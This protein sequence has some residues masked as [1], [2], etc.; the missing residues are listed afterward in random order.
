MQIE[1]PKSAISASS[2]H[3]L[4][5]ADKFKTKTAQSYV[6]ELAM[7]DIGIVDDFDN[8]AMRHGRNNQ[9]DAYMLAVLPTFPNAVWHDEY[10]AIDDRCGASPDVL[11]GNIPLD[12]K[13]PYSFYNY[14]DNI[15]SVKKA[16][17]YQLQMQMIATNADT[18]YLLFYCTKPESYG[19]EEWTEFPIELERRIKLLEFAK[20]TAIQD[21]IMQA[22]DTW[23]PKKL[24]MVEKLKEAETIDY[25]RFFFDTEIGIEYRQ[26]SDASNFFNVSKIYRLENEFFYQLNK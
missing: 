7:K 18:S 14:Y 5:P 19:M 16:Y 10:I 20:D 21:E 1:K 6:L 11:I 25:D 24:E 26:F 13:C 17:L 12:V 22:V 8:A 15:R 4:C 3:K 2:V 23:H 9:H